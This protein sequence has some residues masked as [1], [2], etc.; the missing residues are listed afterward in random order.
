MLY[1][2]VIVLIP[3]SAVAVKAFSGGIASFWDAV[4][5]PVALTAI[6]VTL[7]V[8]LFVAAIGAVMGT[9]VAWVLVRDKFS[10][11]RFLGALIDLPFALPTIV[12]GLTLLALYGPDSPF[13]IHLAF[14]RAAVVVAL[15]FVTLPFVVRSVQPV[16]MEIDPEVEEA[17][18]SLGASSAITFRRIVFPALRPAI[19]SGAALAFA[20][21]VG[22]IG[23]L[24]LIVGKVQIASIVIFADIE[25]DAPQAAASLSVVL[26]ALSLLVLML[27]RRVGDAL[28][29][30]RRATLSLRTLALLYLG[31]LLLLPL[32]VVF[33]RTFEHGVGAAWGWMTTPAAIS[34]FWLTV[35]VAAIAVPLNTIFGVGAALVLIRGK[36]RGRRLLDAMIDLPFIVSPVIVGLA[37]ILVYGQDGWFGRWFIDHGIRIIY[38]APG[39]ILA[40]IF[41]SLPFVVREVA[42]VLIE[43]GDEQEQAAATLGR[44]VLANVLAGYAALDPLGSG[45]RRGAEHRPRPRGDRRRARRLLQCGRLNPDPA[46]AGLPAR[47][48]ARLAGGERRIRGRHRAGHNVAGGSAGDDLACAEKERRLMNIEIAGVSKQFGDFTALET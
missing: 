43:V 31:L 39:M 41:V 18:A 1:V 17:A 12:A 36:G 27:I 45:L 19:L 15:L 25:S 11:Q 28:S 8:S 33:L 7:V 4:T 2:S 24:L 6:A 23:S 3:L 48:A 40:T 32:G 10:G 14:T 13:G 9:L 26:L 20:R 35:L 34:A 21:S 37:L 44:L 5:S 42:P 29:I 30:S 22:E 16:L 46:A 38:A 47:L